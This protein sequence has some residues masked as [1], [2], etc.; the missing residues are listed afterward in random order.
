VTPPLNT[1][2]LI[3]LSVHGFVPRG[4]PRQEGEHPWFPLKQNS[5]C[6]LRF[7]TEPW[8]RFFFLAGVWPKWKNRRPVF[9][10]FSSPTQDFTPE[11]HQNPKGTFSRVPAAD[12]M[13]ARV[14]G[15]GQKS[16]CPNAIRPCYLTSK[17]GVFRQTEHD[18]E[19]FSIRKQ[20]GRFAGFF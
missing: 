17:A 16:P 14:I 5:G 7:S 4:E 11:S 18:L 20:S 1:N 12:L 10:H 9:T 8:D 2:F 3:V 19:E 6:H 15:C 13:V